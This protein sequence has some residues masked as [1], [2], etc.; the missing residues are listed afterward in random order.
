[1][2]RPAKVSI[3]AQ[4]RIVTRPSVW[5]TLRQRVSEKAASY[6]RKT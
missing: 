4:W 3:R 1:M 2:R 6:R 5:R